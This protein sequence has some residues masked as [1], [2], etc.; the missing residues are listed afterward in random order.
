MIPLTIAEEIRTTLLDYLTTTFN[1]QDQAVEQALINFFV[2]PNETQPSEGL[3]KGP[4]ISLRLPFRKADPA[5]PLPIE[6]G[7][8][9]TPYAHQLKSFERLTSRAGHQPQP[10]LVTTGTGSGK[11]ECFLYPILD[12]CYAHREEPGIKAIILY[13]MNALATDQAGRLAQMLW[14]DE[15]LNGKVTAG[16][17]IGGEGEQ[18]HTAMGVHHLIDDRVALRKRPPDIL[19]TNYRMLDFLLLRPEDKTLWAENTPETLRFLV[20][21]ELHTYDGAQGSDV[22]CLIRRLKARL[23]RRLLPATRAIPASCSPTM[24]NKYLASNL[25]PRV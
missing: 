15:R 23:N 3:F 4:Y 9:F 8:K 11:T 16:M 21:D 19:L 10:T 7:P 14:N 2:P 5:A 12:Y 1:F 17:Y 18:P 6:I 24:P 20:L 22:A 25:N 13:P